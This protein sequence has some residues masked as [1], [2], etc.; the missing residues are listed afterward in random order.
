M[1]EALAAAAFFGPAWRRSRAGISAVSFI[2]IIAYTLTFSDVACLM[3]SA[4]GA[5][6]LER[7]RRRSKPD[8]KFCCHG[9]RRFHLMEVTQVSEVPLDGHPAIGPS[10]PGGNDVPSV[11][12]RDDLARKLPVHQRFAL[13]TLALEE[14]SAHFIKDATIQLERPHP[15]ALFSGVGKH[16]MIALQHRRTL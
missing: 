14:V 12:T 7:D 3:F 13:N 9:S 5:V 16:L 15:C 1:S 11:G 10:R 4:W 6:E 2:I 8:S